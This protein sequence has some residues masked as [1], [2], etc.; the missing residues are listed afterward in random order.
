MATIFRPPIITRRWPKDPRGPALR[1]HGETRQNPLLTV[2]KSQDQFFGAAGQVPT[3]ERPNP[4]RPRYPIVLRTF[5]NSVE[6]QL[7]GKDLF[8]GAPGQVVTYQ[9]PPNPRGKPYPTDL[10]TFVNP[11]ELP[12]FGQDQFFGAAGQPPAYDP[13]QNPG[14][15]AYPSDLRTFLDA[16]KL[17]L[18][19]QD[20]FFGAPGQPPTYDWPV[21][22][23]RPPIVNRTWV[24]NLLQTTLGAVQV[25]AARLLKLLGVGL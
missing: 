25:V 19:G 20:Q 21:P 9:P 7:I 14:G 4:L 17:N 12:L 1:T 8:F 18:Q 24:G 23:A 16:L 3:Y 5:T 6:L 15:H 10:R 11:L 22:R 2:L 13:P